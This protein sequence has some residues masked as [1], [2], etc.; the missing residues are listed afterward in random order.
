MTPDQLKA[1]AEAMQ[2][3]LEERPKNQDEAV[4]ERLENLQILLAQSGE[5]L[6]QA[7]FLQDQLIHSEIMKVIKEG[8]TEL[9]TPSVLN[10]FVNALAKDINYLV[11]WLDRINSAAVHQ[12][13]ALRSIL[14]YRKAQMNL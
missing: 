6:A 7:R 13:D 12:I 14:S 9:L 10:K 3:Y 4:I 8:Y 2:K 1:K 11:N 5:L